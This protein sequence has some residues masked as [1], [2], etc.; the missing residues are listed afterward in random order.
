MSSN[1]NGEK[2]L[3]VGAGV[4]GLTTAMLLNSL[5]YKT[6][7]ISSKNP[8]SK[9]ADPLFVSQY[10]SASVIPHSIF[11]DQAQ[12]IFSDSKIVFSR[13]KKNHFPGISIHP[14][15]EIFHKSTEEF[16]YLSSM[17]NIR[18][19]DEAALPFSIPAGF[20][21]SSAWGY[22]CYFADWAVYY[23]ALLNAC[24]NTGSSLEITTLAS[25]EWKDLPE[26]II[27]NCSELGTASLFPDLFSEMHLLAGHLLYIPDPIS[28]YS[29]HRD[30]ISY[31]I[32]PPSSVY[33]PVPDYSMDIYSYRRNDGWI[34][35]GSRIP[36]TINSDGRITSDHDHLL[37]AAN[38]PEQIFE[39]N[40]EVI[41]SYYNIDLRDLNEPLPKMS[42]RLT[43]PTSKGLT[44]RKD[45]KQGKTVIHNVGHGGAGVT[46]SWGCS[47]E[48]LRLLQG[49]HLQ[50]QIIA[51][52]LNPIFER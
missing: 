37:E 39:L 5:G 7:I 50:A 49:E 41:L 12:K 46:M 10:P 13:L 32:T 45:S 36:A 27:I 18:S 42:Y 31:N 52:Q 19:L 21:I 43:Y 23:P 15:Y 28:R 8:L 34:L 9:K 38:F 4:S 26:D 2:I 1:K 3:V 29:K 33:G 40:R 14:H 17:D 47:L 25:D 44:I 51:D 22:D 24:L 35:G 30:I 16:W 20:S 6:R 11:S 48:V